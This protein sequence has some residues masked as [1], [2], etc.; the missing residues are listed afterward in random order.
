MTAQFCVSGFSSPKMDQIADMMIRLG[1]IERSTRC[2]CGDSSCEHEDDWSDIARPSE[3]LELVR[4]YEADA[5]YGP[6]SA[7]LGA[8]AIR[9][10][11]GLPQKT[12]S[13]DGD[14]PPVGWGR[15]HSLFRSYDDNNKEWVTENCT[16]VEEQEWIPMRLLRSQSVCAKINPTVDGKYR[17]PDSE[18]PNPPSP[19]FHPGRYNQTGSNLSPPWEKICQPFPRM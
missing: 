17:T 11:N 18:P 19:P 1:K 15:W 13:L 14:C 12:L 9:N 8:R 6:W 4:I 5:V 7:R 16:L 3:Y 2:R 10:Q